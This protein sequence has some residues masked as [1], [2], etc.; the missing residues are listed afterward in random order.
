MSLTTLNAVFTLAIVLTTICYTYIN[1]RILREMQRARKLALQPMVS[2]KLIFSEKYP[3]SGFDIKSISI[4]NIGNAPAIRTLIESEFLIG[5]NINKKNKILLGQLGIEE[6]EI[7]LSK[8]LSEEIDIK[9]EMMKEI[10]NGN[11]PHKLSLK[12][13]IAYSNSY[14]VP[15]ES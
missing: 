1:G 3:K 12:M 14:G 15:F 7:L 8:L 9:L 10:Y 13:K 6:M 4:S 11:Q 5:E 2:G